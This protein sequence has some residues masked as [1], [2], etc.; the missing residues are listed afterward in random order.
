MI[1]FTYYINFEAYPLKFSHS[2]RRLTSYLH[3]SFVKTPQFDEINVWLEYIFY[4]FFLYFYS[5]QGMEL[6][7]Q[8]KLKL[9]SDFQL[10]CRK[11]KLL[12][13]YSRFIGS[14]IRIENS[15]HFFPWFA[16]CAWYEMRFIVFNFNL[17][18]FF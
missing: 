13:I 1:S 10:D 9:I 18:K 8:N 3:Q 15:F 7:K 6:T 14:T 17:K 16:V 4:N 5:S 11:Q 12:S 2:I